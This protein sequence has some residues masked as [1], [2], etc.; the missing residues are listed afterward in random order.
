MDAESQ[1]GAAL[2]Y[3]CDDRTIIRAVTARA[4]TSSLTPTRR[5][6]SEGRLE[7]AGQPRWGRKCVS[8]ELTVCVCVQEADGAPASWNRKYFSI[9]L[10]AAVY[11]LYPFFSLHLEV[12]QQKR[13]VAVL[14]ARSE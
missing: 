7:G 5:E 14:P 4:A 10:H 12:Q 1:T 8:C 6:A 2:R 13:L 9:G 11:F 3:R